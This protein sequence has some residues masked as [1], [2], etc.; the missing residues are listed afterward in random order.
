MAHAQ[1]GGGDGQ[2]GAVPLPCGPQHRWVGR[3]VGLGYG[4][5]QEDCVGW[6]CSGTGAARTPTCQAGP[7]NLCRLQTS[8]Y[9]PPALLAASRAS[10]ACWKGG[11]V[12]PTL[13]EPAWRSAG[14]I[15]RPSQ[16]RTEQNSQA[17]RDSLVYLEAVAAASVTRSHPGRRWGVPNDFFCGFQNIYTKK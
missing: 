8:L 4:A 3:V 10:L 12:Q 14:T 16:N 9:Q 1:Q 6:P 13:V 15:C 2:Q 7:S 5:S 17:H 11:L